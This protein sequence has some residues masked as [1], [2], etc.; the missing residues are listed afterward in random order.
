MGKFISKYQELMREN[1]TFETIIRHIAM[2]KVAEDKHTDVDEITMTDTQIL[3]YGDLIIV[4]AEFDWGTDYGYLKIEIT[5]EDLSE[6]EEY[7][8]LISK[9]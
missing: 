3:S 2:K 4:T 1:A 7:Q 6:H 8:Q 5:E 9:Y